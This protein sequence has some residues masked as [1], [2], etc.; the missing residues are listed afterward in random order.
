MT[1]GHMTVVIL[2]TM[3]TAAVDVTTITV[4]VV[5]VGTMTVAEI[6]TEETVIVSAVVMAGR[7]IMMTDGTNILA[8][9]A[10]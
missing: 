6:M 8:A 9:A 3:M 1:P 7:G 4:G 10:K 5:V 2:V